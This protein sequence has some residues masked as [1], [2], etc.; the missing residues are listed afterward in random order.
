V[1]ES[2]FFTSLGRELLNSNKQLELYCLAVEKRLIFTTLFAQRKIFAFPLLL[3]PQSWHSFNDFKTSPQIHSL[4]ACLRL[5]KQ[6]Q[7]T[8]NKT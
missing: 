5:F 7:R 8:F 2:F 6:Q 4:Q 1:N 3:T